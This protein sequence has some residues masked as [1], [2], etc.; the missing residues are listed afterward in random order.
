MR[1]VIASTP[2][3]ASPAP[4]R[5]RQILPHAWPAVLFAGTAIY[6]FRLP[7]FYHFRFIGNPDRWNHYLSFAL[8][9]AHN[10][11]HRSFASWSEFLFAG[12]DTLALPFSFFSPLFA[13]PALL[14]A[15]DPIRVLGYASPVI[16]GLAMLATYIVLY[17]VC[18]RRLAATAGAL[19]Y[20]LSTWSL[21]KLSQN[22][23]SY[24]AVGIAPV[25]FL[26][27]HTARPTTVGR[28]VIV[29]T[30]L[31]WAC[32]YWS[33]LQYFSYV[34]IFLVVYASYRRIKGESA[35]LGALGV[36]LGLAAFLALPR[37]L[38]LYENTA[39]SSR[40]TPDIV[41]LV[42]PVLFARYLDGDIFGRSPGQAFGLSPINMSE[43]NLLFASIFASLLFLFIVVRRRYVAVVER[44][45]ACVEVQ[46][47]FFVAFAIVV[48]AVIHLS[49]VYRSFRL[50]YGG[51][52]FLH[53]RFAL[54]G[55]FPIS[56][57]SSLYLVP[58]PGWR[59]TR[60]RALIVG[61]L[62]AAVLLLGSVNFQPL[63]TLLL[64]LVHRPPKPFIRLPRVGVPILAV[65]AVRLGVLSL[66][67]ALALLA[68]RR[69]ASLDAGTFRIL[70][71]AIIIGQAVLQADHYMNGPDTRSYDF[72]FERL[73]PVM[74]RPDEFLPPIARQLDEVHTMLDNDHFRSILICPRQVIPI[75]CS[76]A[77][78]MMWRIRLAEGY[79]SGIPR[80]YR[81]L[82]WPDENR[83]IRALRFSEAE[84]KSPLPWRLLSLLNVRNAIV[85]TRPFYTNSHFGVMRDLLVLR[86]P[87][88]YIYPRAYF[89]SEIRSMTTDEAVKAVRR[90][91]SR[92]QPA[93][94]CS[95]LLRERQ[96]LDYVDGLSIRGPFD[97]TGPIR[98][99]FQGD[100]DVLEF[101]PSPQDR[102]LIVNEAYDPR[103]RAEIDGRSVPV[104][105][106]NLVMRGIL[107][108]PNATR[109]DLRYRSVCGDT[110]RYLAVVI[111]LSAL[112][113]FAFR[114]LF[115]RLRAWLQ[116]SV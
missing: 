27:V 105:P 34:A 78:G 68:R 23:N 48:F 19:V 9:H 6:L 44:A 106:T 2:P 70:L 59:C 104:H 26:L 75:D 91:F 74:A 108:P 101:P 94:G 69:L 47:G 56:L 49:W 60:N 18:R 100:H 92:C 102:F 13:V 76:T 54:A 63:T 82:P 85:V 113:W 3:A 90:Y 15:T 111:P 16:L 77:L 57:V 33:F 89:A 67:F 72:P 14:G 36:S 51:L 87:S 96:P 41:E 12:F 115:R 32:I 5:L 114:S 17:T 95:D 37:L 62:G 20:T 103:W 7:L 25:L 43:G 22:D 88:P 65:E 80:R 31:I 39:G 24:L 42:S 45:G 30:I 110:W 97:A 10:L 35:P 73:D 53:T 64:G 50:L 93:G 86:N 98:S 55:L 66:A 40:T 109:V 116:A 21:L 107:V 46:Y 8:F 11:G 28:R 81:A 4:I 52:S 112:A 79:L 38:I 58:Q 84:G 71:S 83:E 61:L 99:Q 29:L 1:S